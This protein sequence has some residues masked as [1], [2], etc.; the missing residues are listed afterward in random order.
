VLGD[1]IPVFC[2][3]FCGSRDDVSGGVVDCGAVFGNDSRKRRCGMSEP[4]TIAAA[5]RVLARDIVCDDGVATLCL[6]EAANEIDRLAAEVERLRITD[7]EREAIGRQAD[8]LESKSRQAVWVQQG[9]VP[10]AYQFSQEAATLRGLQA[11]H[12]RETV[13]E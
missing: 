8:W 3:V 2:A 10:L 5:L 11:R 13:G 7:A 6:H 9:Q 1:G 4:A 12:A